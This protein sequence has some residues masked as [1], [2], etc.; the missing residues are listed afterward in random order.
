MKR[1]LQWLVLLCLVRIHRVVFTI[2]INYKCNLLKPGTVVKVNAGRYKGPGLIEEKQDFS[3][4]YVHV[5]L[6][7]NEDWVYHIKDV[8]PVIE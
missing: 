2:T 4:D 6:P 8:K 7:H 1:T 5:V 3:V